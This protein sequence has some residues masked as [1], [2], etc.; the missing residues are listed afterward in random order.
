MRVAVSASAPSLDAPV[1]SRFG[2][3]PYFVFVDADTLQMIEAVENPF[4]GQM[5]GVGIQVAQWMA[6]KGIQAVITG[7]VGPKAFE[8]LRMA[9]IP[10]YNAPQGS[11][12]QAVEALKRGQLQ[13][14]GSATSAA[15]SGGGW[16]RGMG[17]GMGM[18]MGMGMGRGMYGGGMGPVAAPSVPTPPTQSGSEV[19]ELRSQIQ[20]MQQMLEKIMKRL[21]DL[22][23]K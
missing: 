11:V 4:A 17:R 21:E 8:G 19:N 5:S 1:E 7:N 10:V 18:G 9:G 20:T 14:L 16:G 6:D 2:R 13:Q 15:H 22:E 12:K 3:A 23:K